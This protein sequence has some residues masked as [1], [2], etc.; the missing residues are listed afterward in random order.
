MTPEQLRDG[1]RWLAT[2][3]Y[4]LARC[5]KRAARAIGNPALPAFGHAWLKA[6][7]YVGLNLYQF[8]QWHY[9][10]VPQVQWLYRQLVSV[11][12]FRYLGDFVKRSNFGASLPRGTRASISHHSDSP[13]FLSQ[14]FKRGRLVSLVPHLGTTAAPPPL[15]PTADEIPPPPEG[16][17]LTG[18]ALSA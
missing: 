13:F 9:R 2:E 16:A 5:T 10:M 17:R 11:N 6:P 18:E 4:S 3:Y 14:G 1:I 12:K 15:A 8:W 7:A